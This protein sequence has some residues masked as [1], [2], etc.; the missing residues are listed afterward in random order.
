MSFVSVVFSSPVGIPL[1]MGVADPMSVPGTIS[2]F[3]DDSA[4]YAPALKACALFGAMRVVKLFPAASYSDIA[5]IMFSM[6]TPLP[7][8]VLRIRMK[9]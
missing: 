9:L 5:K 2:I 4:M 1:T 6:L 7:P 8:F 3:V